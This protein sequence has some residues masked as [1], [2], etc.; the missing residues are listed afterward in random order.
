MGRLTDAL[1][2][3]AYVRNVDRPV[4]DL[5]YGGQQGWSPNLTEW[6]SNQAYVSRPLICLVLEVPKMF[7]IMPDSQ[8]WIAACKSLFETHPKSID[9]FNAGLKVDFDSHPVGGAGEIQEE[10]INVTREPSTPKFT[11]TEK[12]GRPIQTFL[13]YWIRYGGMDPE[14]KFA[15]ISTLSGGQVTDLLAD[16]FTATCLFIE[17]DPMHKN[18]SKAWITTNMFPKGTGDIT[19]KRDLT[20][21]QEILTLDIEFTAISQY[22]I[23]VN[24]F[25]QDILS[26]IKTTHADPNMRP[27]YV[28]KISPDVEAVDRGYQKWTETVGS[29]AVTNMD[30]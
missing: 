7:T 20:S 3:G 1:M 13:E 12:Y 5:K 21:S 11:F 26:K 23:G 17:P 2:Q 6:V 28:D 15:L 30:K 9:G 22:G 19:A 25:A 10:I 24:K 16:W 8:K 29:T 14:A 27:S 4:L 18:V